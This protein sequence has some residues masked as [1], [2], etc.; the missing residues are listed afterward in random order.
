ML[1]LTKAQ[2]EQYR[3][4]GFL[5]LDRI[6]DPEDAA[7]LKTRYEP[8]FEKAEYE[9]GLSPDEV[10]KP[11]GDP[12]YTQQICNGWRADLTVAKIALS[13]EIGR[14][15]AQL[16]G[17]P[18]ARVQI[19]NLLWKPPGGRAIG[20]HQDSAY[21]YWLDKPDMTTCWIALD[22]TTA[23]GGSL[24]YVVGS[25][26]W[27]EA[28]PILQ[29]HGPEDD[30]REAREW[31]EKLGLELK[32]VPIVVP[33]GGGAFHDGWVWHGSRVNKTAQPRRSI[34]I[35]TVS[36]EVRYNPNQLNIG[37]GPVYGRYMRFGSLEVDD[38]YFPITWHQDGKRTKG[39][40]YYLQHGYHAAA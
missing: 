6:I 18:G 3:E 22:Q 38:N 16:A 39:L 10:N 28:K 15:C 11:Q 7:K 31:A 24:M 9:T 25:H 14:A 12:P 23:E 20:F 36:S 17:W 33:P 34:S 35:H 40:D 37:T 5:I 13:E 27:G 2:I 29:F 30:L 26:R 8:M 21:L 32:L 19:D 4:E 1:E